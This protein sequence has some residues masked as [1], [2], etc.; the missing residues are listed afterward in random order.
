MSVNHD[1]NLEC[2]LCMDPFEMDDINFYPCTCKYQICRFCWHRIRTDENGL[3]PACRKQYPEDPAD[4]KPLSVEEWQKIKNEKR[5]KD[6]QKK[7]KLSESRKHLEN[8]RVV[9]KNL[10]FVVGLPTRLADA[11]V[12][13]KYDYFG[14]FGKIHKVVVNQSTN[15][16]GYQGP[17]ASAYV[18]Y[19]RPED[20]LRA[21]K[22]VNNIQVDGRTLKASLGTT[23]YCSNF[24][25]NQQCPKTD[26][27]YLHELGD[28]AASFT[29]EDMQQGKHQ[30]YEK[31]L[32]DQILGCNNNN[33]KQT[34]SPPPQDDSTNSQKE[35]W[36]CT[37]QN[38]KE[39][40]TSRSKDSSQNQRTDGKSNRSKKHT[41]EGQKS[42]KSKNKS[43]DS[44]QHSNASKS[45]TKEESTVQRKSQKSKHNKESTSTQPIQRIETVPATSR[46]N[47]LS[48]K[49]TEVIEMNNKNAQTTFVHIAE[50]QSQ[51]KPVSASIKIARSESP[52]LPPSPISSSSSSL[53]TPFGSLSSN[54]MS[55]SSPSPP[56]S[57]NPLSFDNLGSSANT[58][59]DSSPVNSY[60]APSV[61]IEQ[62]RQSPNPLF[63]NL[64]SNDSLFSHMN[65]LP[66]STDCGSYNGHLHNEESATT[67]SSDWSSNYSFGESQKQM[68]EDDLDFD[69]WNESSKGLADLIAKEAV[70]TP[71]CSGMPT[72]PGFFQ[73]IKP[74]VPNQQRI[75]VPPP[76]FSSRQIPHTN[77]MNHIQ[78]MFSP[79]TE[80]LSNKM[81][82]FRESRQTLNNCTHYY[83]DA[84]QNPIGISNQY[85]Q[86]FPQ[87]NT[88]DIIEN[89][90]LKKNCDERLRTLFPDMLYHLGQNR[91][92]Q[93]S[94]LQNG[95]TWNSQS[96]EHISWLSNEIPLLNSGNIMDAQRSSPQLWMKALQ[97][98]TLEENQTQL[99]GHSPYAN[100]FLREI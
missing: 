71:A 2:P 18:T 24:L 97:Q 49:L 77:S 46:G 11:E 21:I 84:P 32:Q 83:Q 57:N 40:R 72:P 87:P 4:F 29:K 75:A 92:L 52:G 9:Q 91:N 36:P 95:P 25:K 37:V 26:C 19:C 78:G 69:P 70:H 81:S 8:V 48:G 67:D 100:P 59:E 74:P 68:P 45:T 64:E 65:Y 61:G 66:A 53:F 82:S 98:L 44:G 28:E 93:K 20:A 30:E 88:R 50:Q 16:A 38:A 56:P 96:R 54:F 42:K 14:K 1:Q 94:Q 3:C 58:Q 6:Q 33:R 73:P 86:Q 43:S 62:K 99:N 31:K 47:G 22:S 41:S 60:A 17:S 79:N 35:S 5:Q 55:S 80:F 39:S 13:K 51:P 12:L 90:R 85:K 27:M 7:Q 76:G 63:G 23:K 34:V 10:V 89:I 15:Y